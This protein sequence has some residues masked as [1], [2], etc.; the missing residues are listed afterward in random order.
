MLPSSTNGH[1]FGSPL[2]AYLLALAGLLTIGPGLIHVFLPDGGAGV[3]A[4][5]DLS[6]NGAV[7]VGTFAWA[8]ATQIVWGI[9]LLVASLRYRS[10]VPPLLVLL[11]IERSLIAL[12]LWVL[13]AP[14]S[15]HHPPAAYGTLVALPLLA[16][17]LALSLRVRAVR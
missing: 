17:A 1:Y 16:A 14:S 8:G 7:I 12:N 4:G 13:R 9:T 2:A 11:L 5:L 3:I 10:F 6:R 15:G